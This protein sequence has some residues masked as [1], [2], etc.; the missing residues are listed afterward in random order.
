MVVHCLRQGHRPS[1]AH[2]HRAQARRAA[3]LQPVQGSRLGAHGAERLPHQADVDRGEPEALRQPVRDLH[4][5]V[6]VTQVVATG[7]QLVAPLKFQPREALWR[8]QL[9]RW[10]P[11]E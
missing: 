11:L 8:E 10:R 2:G 4:V 1:P 6:V 9:H 5:V 7:V 3:A